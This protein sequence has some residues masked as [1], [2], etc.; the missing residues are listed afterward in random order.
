[1][2]FQDTRKSLIRRDRPASCPSGPD[3]P[4]PPADARPT[5]GRTAEH[6]SLGF[7]LDMF[8]GDRNAAVRDPAGNRGWITTHVEDVGPEELARR[9]R[10]RGR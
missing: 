4:R 6:H 5:G 10:E 2:P 8:Y 9:A 1:M 7:T 3:T